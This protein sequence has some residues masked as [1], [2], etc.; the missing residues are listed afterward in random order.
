MTNEIRV[1]DIGPVEDFFYPMGGPG[2]HVLRGPNGS[3]KTT[4]LRTAEMIVD[5]Q[6]DTR[7]QKRDGSKRGVAT[8]SGKTLRVSTQIRHEG[9]ISLSGCGDLSIAELHTPKFLKVET[10]DAHRIKTLVRLSGVTADAALF[11]D[12]LPGRFDEVVPSDSIRADDLVDMAA[13]VKRAIEAKALSVEKFEAT[14]ISDARAQ[15]AIAEGVDLTIPHDTEKLQTELEEAIREQTAWAAKLA[16]LQASRA[17]ANATNERARA[18]RARLEQMVA[19]PSVADATM[20][21][22]QATAAVDVVQ[23][24]IERLRSKLREAEATKAE[25]VARQ[26]AAEAALAAAKREESLHAEL[27]AAI[28]AG[29]AIGPTDTELDTARVQSEEWATAIADAKRAITTGATVRNAIAAQAK[30]AEHMDRAKAL[31]EEKRRLRDAATDTATVLTRAI[32]NLEGCPLKIRLSESGDPR[33]VIATD[34]SD[35]EYF[36]DLSDGEKWQVVVSIAAQS[37]RLIVLPQSAFGE[38]APSTRMQIHELAKRNSCYI[39]TAVADDC[40]L[41]GEAYAPESA[42]AE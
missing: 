19:S 34:R 31:G 41:H 13:R 25:L 8:L 28:D 11:R 9:E 5:G 2:L 7:L 40:E 3:G 30:S 35:C 20:A 23:A 42:V 14:A 39:L 21:D 17:A 6:T 32:A 4:I 15:A 18:A 36:E 38:L 29:G 16:E 37:N 1:N 22:D 27:K 26:E 33:L 24:Q 10:R 12:L